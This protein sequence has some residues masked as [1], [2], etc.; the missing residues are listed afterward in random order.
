[1]NPD[2]TPKTGIPGN[3]SHDEI[4]LK[5]IRTFQGDVADAIKSQQESLYSI[6]HQE[7]KKKE[8]VEIAIEKG[9]VKQVKV[10]LDPEAAR[11]R[12]NLLLSAGS[13]LLLALGVV[14][15]YFGYQEF[16]TRSEAPL[17]EQ[18]ANRFLRSAKEVEVETVSLTRDTLVGKIMQFE[19]ADIPKDGIL[20]V[21]YKAAPTSTTTLLSTENFLKLVDSHAPS[22]LVR[23]FDRLFMFGIIGTEEDGVTTP[24]NFILI[25]LVSF[26]NAFP[27]MLAWEKTL[28]DDLLALFTTRAEVRNIPT[29]ASFED[30]TIRNKDAR[31]LR[32]STG[33]IVLLYS[34]FENNMLVITDNEETFRTL[35]TRL[36]NEKLVR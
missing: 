4:E 23:A 31:V 5:Q 35:V 14:G 19:S 6:Q 34:F 30:I 22:S 15:A 17:I 3:E 25:K 12:K 18:P 20:H 2:G 11:R 1:M 10:P 29:G 32:D 27:G 36:T 16:R 26:E 28:A 33:K 24:S 9:E 7:Q 21:I 13:I 8:K